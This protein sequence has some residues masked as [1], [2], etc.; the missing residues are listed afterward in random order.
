MIKVVGITS[1]AISC[2]CLSLSNAFPI[3]Q[4]PK[5]SGTV[6]QVLVEKTDEEWRQELTAEQ[7]FVL[8]EEG[9]ER[10]NSSELNLVKDS[11]TFVCAGCNSPLFTTSTKYES[12]TGWPS[13]YAPIDNAAVQNSLDIKLL[14]PRTEV[15]CSTCGGHLGHVF[16]D[17]PQ[18]TGQR[19]CMNGVAMKFRSD[20]E[21]PELASLVAERQSLSPYRLDALQILP[22]IMFNG[23]MGGL[24]FNSFVTRMT[25]TGV[26]TPLDAFPLL[27]AIYF[28]TLAV[29]ACDRL[30]LT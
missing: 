15:S 25:E 16:E 1:F 20:M 26:N 28:G 29:Q 17:G 12:G 6:R 22:G 11:G 19:Y 30:K 8:R 10:P 5:P 13:F 24:F 23:I 2:C 18:P 21:Y 3:P 7:F 27:P 4:R 9:T 14:V